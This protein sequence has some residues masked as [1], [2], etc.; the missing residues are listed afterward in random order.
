MIGHI[1]TLVPFFTNATWQS[2]ILIAVVFICTQLLENRPAVIRQTLWTIALFGSLI[3]PLLNFGLNGIG[4]RGI[5]LLEVTQSVSLPSTHESANQHLKEPTDGEIGESC[6][7][8]IGNPHHISRLTLYVILSNLLIS[9]WG[10]GIC[11][12]ILR[13]ISGWLSLGRIRRASVTET[14]PSVRQ[15]LTTLTNQMDVREA[16]RPGFPQPFVSLVC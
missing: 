11:V 8:A 13:L 7:D 10:V 5:S 14:N 1:H 12:A 16:S 15:M 3:V 6:N 4:G 2:S 9:F